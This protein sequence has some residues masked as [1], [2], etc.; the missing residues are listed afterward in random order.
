MITQFSSF[1]QVQH[2]NTLHN[3]TETRLTHFLHTWREDRQLGSYTAIH[4]YYGT[5]VAH[6]YIAHYTVGGNTSVIAL[7]STYIQQQYWPTFD[8][9]YCRDTRV[10]ARTQH[11]H[12]NTCSAHAYTCMYVCS[13]MC[14]QMHELCTLIYGCITYYTH[15]HKLQMKLG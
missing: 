11:M 6:L 14:T 15:I 13:H 5:M 3:T 1:L 8:T 2:C 4:A 9:N 7:H 12:T 10:H